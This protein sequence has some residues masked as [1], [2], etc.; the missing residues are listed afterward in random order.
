MEAQRFV[1]K[2]KRVYKRTVRLFMKNAKGEMATARVLFTTEHLV[3]SIERGIGKGSTKV[4]AEA[5]VR[6]EAILEAMYRDTGYGKVFVHIDDPDGKRKKKPYDVTAEDAEK[7][8]LKGMFKK[9]GLE[10]DDNKP[11]SVLKKELSL[12]Y[13]LTSGVKAELNPPAPIEENP[14]NVGEEMKQ[15][16]LE[17]QKNAKVKYFE[18]YGEQIPEQYLNDKAFLDGMYNEEFDPKEY[19]ASMNSNSKETQEEKKKRL[20]EEYKAKYSERVP[21]LKS[22]DFSWIEERLK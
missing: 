12:H 21:N 15:A 3:R 1:L 10:F 16:I 22:N 18:K 6:D 20:H 2:R 13:E 11:M 9:A 7:V 5:V 8:A 14:I 19:I 17:S 4:S